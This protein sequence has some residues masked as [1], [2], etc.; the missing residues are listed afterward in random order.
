[1]PLTKKDITKEISKNT[2]INLSYS[3]ALLESFIFLIKK[4]SKYH[5]IKISRFGTFSYKITPERIG[6]N[7]KTKESYIIGSRE[8]LYLQISNE[9]KKILN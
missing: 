9:I 8:K 3:K 5:D 2:D 7:P 6:R 4:N 1:M